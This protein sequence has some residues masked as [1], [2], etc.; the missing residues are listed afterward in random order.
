MLELDRETSLKIAAFG[1]V[2]SFLVAAIH[3]PQPIP[4]DPEMPAWWLY[5]LTA[6]TFGR[7][8]VPFYFVVAGF[9]LARHFGEDSWWRREAAKRLRSLLVPFV[10][11]LLLWN[12]MEGGLA[13]ASNI[14]DGAPA[15]EGFPSGWGLLSCFGVNPFGYPSDVPLWFVRSLLL[16]VAASEI[17]LPALRRFGVALPAMV[18]AVSAAARLPACESGIWLFLTRF[19]SVHGLFY[20]LVGA[21]LAMG[22]ATSLQCSRAVT[23]LSVAG[24]AGLFLSQ[25][26]AAHGV[27]VWGVLHELSIPF[28]LLAA[29][30]IFPSVSWSKAITSLTFP[31]YILHVFAVRALD[32]V[33]YGKTGC[34]ALT[35]KYVAVCVLSTAAAAA[36]R[37]LL[38]RFHAFAFGG[39]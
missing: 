23:A 15:I 24:I 7:L 33:M 36:S 34:L 17:L 32:V 19:V 16:Y 28:A 21:A 38:P 14:R 30:R 3:V 27:A 22:V 11:W 9:F 4:A 6:G 13:A 26:L 1:F 29:W 20:F 5:R 37:A 2:C 35:V 18:L 12:A 39:R 8:A 10:I 25:I 31:I